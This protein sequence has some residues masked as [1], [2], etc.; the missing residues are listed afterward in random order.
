[1]LAGDDIDI[2]SSNIDKCIKLMIERKINQMSL[3]SEYLLNNIDFIQNYDLSFIKGI[4]ITRPIK[5]LSPVYNLRNL[6]HITLPE[7]YEGKFDFS[8][9]PKLEF[10]GTTWKD[11]FINLGTCHEMKYLKIFG[12][13]NKDLSMFQSLTKLE[14]IQLTSSKMVSLQGIENL[15]GLKIL[16][17]DT[18]KKLER[19]EGLT[20]YN[21]NLTYLRIWI[22][23]N[24]HDVEPIGHLHNLESIQISKVKML[25]SLK[26]L[27]NLHKLKICA[28]HPSNID[29]RDGDFTPLERAK[30]RVAR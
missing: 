12:F 30:S 8:Y 22:A 3:T 13:S 28:I 6:T 17:I 7:D 1:M 18:A 20:E 25:D 27:D 16:D 10:L 29:V 24:L 5:D 9:L 14:E 2:N 19:L 15:A 21:H 23:P 4:Y 26:F 11:K